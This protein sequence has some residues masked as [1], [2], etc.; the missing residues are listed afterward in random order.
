MRAPDVVQSKSF[1]FGRRRHPLR[2]AKETAMHD[3]VIRGATVIDGLG[4][5][6]R[7]ADVAIANGRIIAMGDVGKDAIQVID[8]GGLALMPGDHRPSY[9]LRRAGYLGPDAVPLAIAWR[10]DSRD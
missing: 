3:L 4:H 5:D 7:R 10:H 8:G 6:P 2:R 1:V 9:P